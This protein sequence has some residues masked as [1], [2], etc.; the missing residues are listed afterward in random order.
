MNLK[1]LKSNN[2]VSSSAID[3]IK[4]LHV[5]KSDL[6]LNFNKDV[7]FE[8]NGKPFN[9]SFFKAP[10]LNYKGNKLELGNSYIDTHQDQLLIV[11]E[12]GLFFSVQI[13]AFVG[14][15]VLNV[16]HIESNIIDFISYFEFFSMSKFNSK[17]Y[18]LCKIDYMSQ[19]FLK[20]NQDVLHK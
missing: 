6:K 11:Q 4:Y 16:Q 12:N 20:R 7:A 1:I 17:T 15:S 3:A 13:D 8:Y 10:F 2:K 19:L 18:L 14:N 5:R 9:I